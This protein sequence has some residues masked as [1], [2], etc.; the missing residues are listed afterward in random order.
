ML[1]SRPERRRA[2]SGRLK[3]RSEPEDTFGR[4]SLLASKPDSAGRIEDSP[5]K[6]NNSSLYVIGRVMVAVML[7]VGHA[8]LSDEREEIDITNSS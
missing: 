2:H 3:G 1:D 7:T 4:T 6:Q 5:R 8:P